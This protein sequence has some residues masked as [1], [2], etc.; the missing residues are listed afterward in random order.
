MVVVNDI[1][2]DDTDDD[3]VIGSSRHIARCENTGIHSG[4][5]V[6]SRRVIS[7]HAIDVL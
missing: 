2:D 5:T 6:S 4:K 1:S 3:I 7:N